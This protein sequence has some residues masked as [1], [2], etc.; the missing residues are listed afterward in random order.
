MHKIPTAIAILTMTA[1]G[2][3]A[4]TH[5]W[6]SN[7]GTVGAGVSQSV[8]ELG[9][10]AG[11]NQIHLWGTIEPEQTMKNLSFNI[12]S[13]TDAVLDFTNVT[14]YNPIVASGPSGDVLRYQF[15][16]D[17]ASVPPVAPAAVDP[18]SISNFQGF[19]VTAQTTGMGQSAIDL[20]DPFYDPTANAFLIATVDYNVV[21]PQ[22]S[23][24]ELFLQIGG[25]G[26][27]L[28][29]LGSID[30]LIVFGNPNDP[31]LNSETQHNTD[32]A[33]F[34]ARLTVTPVPEP[35]ALALAALGLMGLAGHGRRQRELHA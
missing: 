6:L 12:R 31:A 17:S 19:T 4:Q 32:S 33:T 2:A 13:T 9:V 23:M 20:G 27:N 8:P 24:T 1:V 34:D 11:A 28:D 21:G 30:T 26:A 7:V 16:S 25:N 18:D 35:C 22:G 14:M 29:G 3:H 10:G 15:L 5:I